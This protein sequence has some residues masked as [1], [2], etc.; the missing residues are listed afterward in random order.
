MR[1]GRRP[2]AGTAPPAHREVRPVAVDAMGGDEAPDV[3]V[4]GAVRAAREGLAVV[5]VGDRDRIAPL[6]PRGG[7]QVIHAPDTI[8]MAD[9]PASV[10]RKPDSS[11]RRVMALVAEG[12]A[13]AAVSCGNTGAVLVAATLDLGVLDGVERPAICTL[14]PRA[15]GGRLVLLDAGA[16]VDC[17]PEQLACFALLG[18]A[19]AEVL[20]IADPRVGLL[21]NGEEDGKGNMQVRATLPLLRSL[22]LR[23]VGNVEPSAAMEGACDVLVCDGFVGNVLLK[24]AEG[25][26]GVVVQLLKEEILGHATSRAGAF[27][28]RGA[29]RRFRDRVAWDAHGGALLLGTRGVVVVGH[30]RANEE[31]VAAAIRLAADSAEGGLVDAVQA[32]MSARLGPG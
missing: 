1:A 3:I 27:M 20:G 15:D 18:A 23:V 24:A 16:N 13:S 11:V 4:A 21:S 5:L 25:A 26:V 7:P 6:V 8:G 14:L 12:Q 29:M 22:P 17:R 30:G 32:R 28:L 19:H 31:A 9:G 2:E 10:R